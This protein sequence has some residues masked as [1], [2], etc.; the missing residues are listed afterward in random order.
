MRSH[1]L[2]RLG[3]R[4]SAVGAA[5]HADRR[6]LAHHV[7]NAAH[8]VA[9]PVGQVRVHPTAVLVDTHATEALTRALTRFEDDALAPVTAVSEQVVGPVVALGVDPDH[10]SA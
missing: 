8:S 7:D 9:L 10:A 2:R 1:A 4:R 3:A 6:R 5:G